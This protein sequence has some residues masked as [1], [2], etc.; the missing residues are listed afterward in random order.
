MA[1]DSLRRKYSPCS[2]RFVTVALPSG[3]H[4][5]TKSAIHSLLVPLKAWVTGLP[6]EST[7][8]KARFSGLAYR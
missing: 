6:S 4:F 7:S 3:D 5:S 8:S 1:P 2:L